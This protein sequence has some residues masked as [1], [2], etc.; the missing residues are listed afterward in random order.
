MRELGFDLAIIGG[1]GSEA[2]KDLFDRIICLTNAT[3][4]Y[5]HLSVLLLNLTSIP[6]SHNDAEINDKL[7][8][9]R[10]IDFLL[11]LVKI[12]NSNNLVISCNSFHEFASSFVG[13]KFNFINM[14]EVTRNYILKDPSR[15][16][17]I[18]A[19]DVTIKRKLYLATKEQLNQNFLVLDNDKQKFIDELIVELK[20]TK[21]RNLDT[22][23][24]KLVTFLDA[25]NDTY[26]F[27]FACTEL[28]LISKRIRSLTN[29]EI[30]DSLDV[31]AIESIISVNSEK[32]NIVEAKKLLPHFTI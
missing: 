27:L 30:I 11:N 15:K 19:T 6:H 7:N 10:E 26:S 4:D 16:I 12:S 9:Q 3:E 13:F 28:S 29:Y 2:A 20:N 14:I 1:M 17:I 31:A 32:L 24:K 5:E 8:P 18:L 21:F 23:A 22:S 25:I